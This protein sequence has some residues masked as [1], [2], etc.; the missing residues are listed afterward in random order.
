MSNR[1]ISARRAAFESLKAFAKHGKYTNLEV[2]ASL[3]R[4]SFSDED[5]RLY[6][7][8]VYGVAERIPTLDYIIGGLSSREFDRIDPDAVTCLRLGLYQI[9]YMDRVPDHAAVSETVSLVTPRSRGF[10]NALLREFLR[11]GKKYEL[12]PEDDTENYFSVKYS[13]PAAMCAF[14]ISKLGKDGAEGLLAASV[15]KRDVAVRVNTLVCSPE[16]L[17]EKVFPDGKVDPTSDGMID[18]PSLH[19]A[20]MTD[21]RWFVQDVS[22]RLAVSALA[23]EPGETVVDT[24]AAPDG[25]SFSAAIDMKNEGSVISFDLHENKIGLIK[26]GAE[27]HGI[28]IIKA[29][30]HD[31]SSPVEE[32]KGK[33]DR[34]LC[35]APCSGLGVMSKKPEDRKSVV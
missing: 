34:V 6:T 5:K 13:C 11:R 12:P 2:A 18:V 17:I 1:E 19:G 30:A 25:K 23:P 20:D 9:V 16:E 10:V 14:L 31:A 28:S 22:S 35:D 21:G 27:R 4:Y 3:S 29:L 33:A 15:S 26:K 32:L 7:A 8:L 24:C